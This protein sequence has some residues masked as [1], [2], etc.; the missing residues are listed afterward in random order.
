LCDL[1]DVLG[2]QDQMNR[3]I[4]MAAVIKWVWRWTW[5]LRSSELRD[6][7]GGRN[8]ASLDTLVGHDQSRWEEYLEGEISRWWIGKEAWRELRLY[9]LVN[10]WLWACIELST[11]RS[12][13]M[14]AETGWEQETLHLRMMH[15]SVYMILNV[16]SWS[17]HAEIER[18]DGTFC[19]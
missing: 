5:R 9:P 14:R 3:E 11:T 4:Q 12:T 19:S 8:G 1:R 15:Y 7:L 13:E 18:N 10:S 2:G 6:A 16:N 17:Y